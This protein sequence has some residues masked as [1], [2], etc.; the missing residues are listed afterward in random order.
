MERSN[1]KHD[2]PVV[3]DR[4]RIRRSVEEPFFKWGNA[5]ADRL[6]ILYDKSRVFT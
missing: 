6:V 4:V 3:G 5:D 2:L 1:I